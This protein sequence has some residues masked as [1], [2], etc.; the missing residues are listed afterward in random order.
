MITN[1]TVKQ[2]EIVKTFGVPIITVKRFA[3]LHRERGPEGFYETRPRRSS[4]SVLK[5]DVL[6]Q[7]Q[8][9]LDQRQSV[10][11]VAAQLGV[12]GNTIHKAIRSGRLHASQNNE[13][14][15]TTTVT[16]KSERNQIDGEAAMGT[17]ATRSLERV[18]AAMGQ[19]ESA[20]IEFEATCDV[21]NGNAL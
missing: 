6:E 12:L 2:Q 20:P 4:A 1:G 11:E 7:A 15:T 19:L 16:N 18:A 14:V 5:G 9:L 13:A 17:G 8:Q 3:K 10:P 21:E